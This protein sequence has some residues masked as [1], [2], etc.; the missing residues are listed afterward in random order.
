MI[1]R[2]LIVDDE[3]AWRE[4][5]TDV[6]TSSGWAADPAKDMSRAKELVQA[7]HYSLIILDIFLTSVRAP[8]NYQNSVTFFARTCPDA[9]IVAATG[10]QLPPDEAFA[11]SRLGVSDFIY[12]PRIQLDAL[13]RLAGKLAETDQA[14]ETSTEKLDRRLEQIEFLLANGLD[15]LNSSVAQVAGLTRALIKLASTDVSD[16]PRL[17]TLTELAGG[18]AARTMR[19]SYSL[20]LWCE[21]PGAEHSW[22]PA[23]YKFSRPKDWLRRIAPYG[24]L[25]SRIL[26][27][28]IPIAANIPG[29]VVSG[30]DIQRVQ[31]QLDLMKA[32]A[33]QLPRTDVPASTTSSAVD[34][35]TAEEGAGLRALRSLLLT[36]DKDRIFGDL[37]KAATGSGEIIWVC[38]RHA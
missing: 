23:T 30:N 3:V 26:S 11:L 7:N 18:R 29:V 21:Y 5:F 1:P 19:V 10:E 16:C 31:H 12:K 24:L 35:L 36:E 25:V 37:R 8:L 4:I 27:I 34:R 33:G 14:E 28:V 13:R 17:F 6:F 2:V 15:T 38:P 32:V 20:T 9:V 22:D